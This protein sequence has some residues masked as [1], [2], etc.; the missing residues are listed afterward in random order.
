MFDQSARAV[1]GRAF[2][3]AGDNQADRTRFRR[4]VVQRRDEGG[5]AAFHIDRA[6]PVQ[7]VTTN[8]GN[9]RI[10]APTLAGW[11]DIKMSGK[12]KMAAIALADCEQ[13][14]GGP[15]VCRVA[16]AFTSDKPLDCETQR[17]QHR[18]KRIKNRAGCRCDALAGDQAFCVGEGDVI[19]AFAG[20]PRSL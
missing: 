13:I 11:Y 19:H 17:H 12:G 4:N 18:F 16:I 5:D 2:F 20:M 9:K 15:A 3:V 8:V 1:N 7:Q 6:A 14:F 10:A